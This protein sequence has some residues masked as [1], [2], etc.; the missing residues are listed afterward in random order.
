VGGAAA[1]T[2][3][4]SSAGQGGGGHAGGATTSSGS[5]G[6]GSGGDSVASSTSASSG[7]GGGPVSHE[8]EIILSELNKP[9]FVRCSGG[10]IY[11]VSVDTGDVYSASISGTRVRQLATGAAPKAVDADVSDDHLLYATS[12]TTPTI[13]SVPTEGG[14]ADVYASG[15]NY[16]GIAVHD[17]DVYWF[18]RKQ[19]V[20]PTGVIR[21]TVGTFSDIVVDD[22]GLYY[23]EDN[24]VM[25]LPSGSV[26]PRR[27]ATS[28]AR[29]DVIGLDPEYVL[30]GTRNTFMRVTRGIGF[31]ETISSTAAASLDAYGNIY[32][33]MGAT[34]VYVKNG[35]AETRLVAPYNG[36]GQIVICAGHAVWASTNDGVIARVLL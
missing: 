20:G 7:A 17:G 2:G 16:A 22:V 12:N 19:I 26:T 14:E 23:I 25:V 13:V 5:A 10:T 21:T 9:A 30:Y 4:A 32:A 1:G 15:S 27:L 18:D 24:D 29:P 3:A 8:P 35:A 6:E 28:D 34:K 33:W 11:W 36:L 31:P